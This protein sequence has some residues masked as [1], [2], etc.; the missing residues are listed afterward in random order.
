MNL[1]K[2][3]TKKIPNLSN[4]GTLEE[5]LIKAKEAAEAANLAL[6]KERDLF[7]RYLSLVEAIIVTLDPN[8]TITMLNRKG[9]ELL[10][11]K[12]EEILGENW[13]EKCLP[14][15]EGGDVYSLFKETMNGNLVAMEYF[16]N[17]IFT[18]DGQKRLIAWHNNYF[19]DANG[20]IVGTISAGEDITERKQAEKERENL[21]T[22]LEAALSEIKTLRGI[23]PICSYCKNIRNDKDSWDQLETYISTHSDAKFSHSI[24]PECV[25]KHHPE[26]YEEIYPD[27]NIE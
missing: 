2:T 1:K 17:E 9:C 7:Q 14:Q 12:E 5:Q 16:E 11:Y 21:I 19:R 26:M 8:G 4:G 6:R 24:C 27:K 23:I 20:Q 22:K 13:F 18:K 10:G 15:P 25:K 3:N